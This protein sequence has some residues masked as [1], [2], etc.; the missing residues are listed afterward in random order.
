ML[1]YVTVPTHPCTHQRYSIHSMTC[2]HDFV[3][4]LAKAVKSFCETKEMVDT[5]YGEQNSRKLPSTDFFKKVKKGENAADQRGINS[6]KA[7]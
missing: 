4:D 1:Y 7:V 2:A 5:V 6:A 3:V